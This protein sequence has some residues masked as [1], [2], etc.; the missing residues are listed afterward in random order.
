MKSFLLFVSLLPSFCLSVN[1]V[2]ALTAL[3]PKQSEMQC[4]TFTKNLQ[5]GSSTDPLVRKE[6]KL[7]QTFL[8]V[9]NYLSGIPT[10]TFGKLTTEGLMSYQKKEGLKVTGLLDVLTKESIAKKNCGDAIR[11]RFGVSAPST[12]VTVAAGASDDSFSNFSWHFRGK[13]YEL[14]VPMSGSLYSYYRQSKKVYTYKGDLPDNW[15]EDYNKLFLRVRVDDVSFDAL[16]FALLELARKENLSSD[17]TA[18]LI[19][20]FVQ[21]IPYDFEKD[22]RTDQTQYPYET[23]YTKKGVCAD[24]TFLMYHLLRRAGYGVAIM[25][26]LEKNH[27]A[28]GIKCGVN[29]AVFSSGYCYVETTTNLPVGVIPTSFGNNGQGVRSLS[30]EAPEFHLLLDTTRLGKADVFLKTEGKSFSGVDDLKIKLDRL[31]VLLKKIQ[32]SKDVVASSSEDLNTRKEFLKT[33]KELVNAASKKDDY[34]NYTNLRTKYNDKVKEYELA[35]S[36]YQEIV[37]A[38]NKDVKEYNALLL[39]LD[40]TK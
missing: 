17:D 9:N 38:Y 35:F 30:L 5:V 13:K 22:T 40:P 1:D 19:V 23:L 16:T 3:T 20:S 29:S 39:A 31:A 25:Q 11:P 15:T 36:L 6:V 18:G 32:D 28:L 21:S 33:E 27:Q 8:G 14:T 4:I 34:E 37:S 24:K 10:G 2:N 12:K 7:L 26:F